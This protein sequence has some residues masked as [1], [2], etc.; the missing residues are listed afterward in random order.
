MW[1]IFHRAANKAISSYSKYEIM[2][3]NVP[4]DHICCLTAYGEP[5]VCTKRELLFHSR[6]MKCMV[7]FGNEGAEQRHL[8]NLAVLAKD[9]ITFSCLFSFF[10]FVFPTNLQAVAARTEYAGGRE[11]FVHLCYTGA[12]PG[13]SSNSLS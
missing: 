13:V 4:Q 7:Y 12:K 2:S 1:I 5:V 9:I 3:A 10:F 8:A 11:H 6:V